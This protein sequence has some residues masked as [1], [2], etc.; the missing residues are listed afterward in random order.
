MLHHDPV[1]LD[2]VHNLHHDK[3]TIL[4]FKLKTYW[5]Q[6]EDLVTDYTQ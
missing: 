4:S 6:L 1:A 5:L 2:E 3:A